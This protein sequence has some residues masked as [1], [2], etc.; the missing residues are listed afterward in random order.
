MEKEKKKEYVDNN[1]L[2]SELLIR[3]EKLI[4]EEGYNPPVKNFVVDH[5]ERVKIPTGY[6]R[7]TDDFSKEYHLN[8][9]VLEKNTK[10]IYHMLYSYRIIIILLLID[11]MYGVQSRQCCINRCLLILFL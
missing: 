7:T 3:N 11:L 4:K 8:E 1:N 10:K 9:L 5:S 6:I 2:I